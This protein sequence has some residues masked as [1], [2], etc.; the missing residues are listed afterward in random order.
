[1]AEPEAARELEP[2][3]RGLWVGVLVYR[4]A[5]FVWMSA[6]AVL[7]RDDLRHSTAALGVIAC[8][9]AWNAWFTATSAWER[10]TPRF[11]DLGISIALLPFSGWVMSEGTTV[12]GAPFFA[13]SYPVSSA[14]T[15]GVGEGL[16]AGLA[17]A[18]GLSFAL[19]LSRPANGTP[20][21][22]LTTEEW[23]ALVNG[24]V[25]YLAAGGA[26]GAVSRVIRS[27]SRERASAIEEATRERE[28]SARLAER[29]TLGREI[30]DSVLQSLALVEK[31]GREA[32]RSGSSVPVEEVEPLVELVTR[33]EEAL[34]A[35]LSDPEP[36]PP[37]GYVSLRTALLAV[38]HETEGVP[39]TVTT[40]S[41]VW[42]PAAEVESL[43]AA[44]RQALDNAVRHAEA[45]R[46]TVFAD[47]H[48]GR[49]EV[50]VRDDGVGFAF[51]EAR[52]ARD[53][54]IGMARS[55]KGR[56]EELGGTMIVRS[57]PG[58]GTEIEFRVPLPGAGT[59]G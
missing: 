39:V 27:T 54:K 1:M 6:L 43:A 50:S 45:S 10:R 33:Q 42:L 8:V 9:G 49:V 21:W 30:H 36:P 11:V 7:T 16:A 15:V 20:L 12:S 56:V 18:G 19:V 23:A 47:A 14:M 13:T 4:W 38:A 37:D 25:Y 31:R 17:A 22:S 46:V 29:E 26:A 58:V 41:Q 32:L 44:V 28:R 55:M 48:A 2:G 52:L 59:G 3:M 24:V 5:S 35:L 40:T 34:R 57:T 51:D 53:G